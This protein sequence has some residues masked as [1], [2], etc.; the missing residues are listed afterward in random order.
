M[1]VVAEVARLGFERDMLLESLRGRQQNKA[2][3]T[4]WLM[5]DNKCVRGVRGGSDAMIH[6]AIICD[7]AR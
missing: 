1:Q 2:T 4:Y 7:E 5:C 3:V 6:D